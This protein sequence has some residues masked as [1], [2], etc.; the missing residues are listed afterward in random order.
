MTTVFLPCR[1][2]SERVP[3]KNTRNFAGIEGGLIQIKL[4]QLLQS[5]KLDAICLSTNDP[6]VMDIAAKISDSRINILMRPDQLASSQTSTDDLIKYVPELIDSGTVVWTHVTSPFM[7]GEAYD[8]I[9]EAYQ[10]ALVSGYDSLATVSRIQTFLW[11]KEG[12]VN[13]DRNKEKWPR[14][15][16]LSPL[17]ELNSGAFVADISIYKEMDDRIGAKPFLFEVDDQQGFDI[18]WEHD[19]YLAE[20]IWESSGF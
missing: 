17:W 7:D 4:L 16:T 13:Y 1:K 18:D 19:F 20:K 2:G 10:K 15:Q 9:I 5:N 6:E 12:P 11:N 8:Q 3:A 14:T